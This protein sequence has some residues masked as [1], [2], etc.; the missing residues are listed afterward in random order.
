[1]AHANGSGD[2][3]SRLQLE[4]L[5]AESSAAKLADSQ[6][7]GLEGFHNGHP[8]TVAAQYVGADPWASGERGA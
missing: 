3:Q 1:M 6:C 4:D 7:A 8:S 2:A 5:L